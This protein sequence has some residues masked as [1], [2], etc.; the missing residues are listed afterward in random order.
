MIVFVVIT[1]TVARDRVAQQFA[2]RPVPA[3][4]QVAHA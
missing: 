2:T 4:R 3:R 1:I